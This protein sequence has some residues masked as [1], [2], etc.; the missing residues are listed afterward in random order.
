MTT[1][2]GATDNGSAVFARRMVMA[3]CALAVAAGAACRLLFLDRAA[4][5]YDEAVILSWGRDGAI[6]LLRRVAEL[7][8]HPPL[9]YLLQLPFARLAGWGVEPVVALRLLP[10]LCGLLTLEAVRRAGAALAGRT[11][12]ALAAALLALLPL[13]IQF[14]RTGRMYAPA[15]LF[16]ALALLALVRAERSGR[17]RDAAALAAC[18]LAAAYTHYYAAVALPF[19][20]L[21]LPVT[22]VRSCVLAPLAALFWGLLPWAWFANSSPVSGVFAD[23]LTG[24][25]PVTGFAALR[26]GVALLEFDPFFFPFAP[27]VL[28]LLLAAALFRARA[29]EDAAPLRLALA[30]ALPAVALALLSVALRAL[31]GAHTLQPNHLALLAP[32]YALAL[33]ALLARVRGRASGILLPLLLLSAALSLL[34]YEGGQAARVDARTL[35]LRYAGAAVACPDEKS[36]FELLVNARPARLRVGPPDGLLPGESGFAR[37]DDAEGR[38]AY[39]AAALAGDA[40]TGRRALLFPGGVAAVLPDGEFSLDFPAMPP[41]FR[42]AA[43]AEALAVGVSPRTVSIPAGPAVVAAST[44]AEMAGWFSG[45][46]APMRFVFLA[47]LAL[48]LGRMGGQPAGGGTGDSPG[49]GAAEAASGEAAS[50]GASA[51]GSGAGARTQPSASMRRRRARQSS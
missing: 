48:A 13:H 7:D 40:A 35:A 5:G 6:E 46:V 22:R 20:L 16:L 51:G 29:R 21:A 19:L 27:A 41:G 44:R 43:D 15:A 8:A 31:Y 34:R 23:R 26:D 10:L 3:A 2:P 25:L 50:G 38:R 47:A 18:C 12:G 14:S 24:W 11:A 49:G 45:A 32:F 42:L 28:P 37:I 17:A 30:C 36:A 4:L 39:A 9:F 33:G 1:A